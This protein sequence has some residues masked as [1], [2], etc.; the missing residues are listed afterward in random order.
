MSS[1]PQTPS[2]RLPLR[3]LPLIA[4]GAVL[5]GLVAVQAPA[6]AL[7]L[8]LAALVACVTFLAPNIAIYAV[9]FI[10][11][12]NLAGVGVAFHGVPKPIAAAFPLLLAIPLTWELL[13]RRQPLIVS[14]VLLILLLYLFVQAVSMAFSSDAVR[15]SDAVLTLAVEGV[16]LYLLITNTVRSTPVL[17]N[18]TWALLLAGLL[19]S[20]VPLYQQVTRTFDNTYGGLAQAEGVGFRT[21]EV[22]EE[23]GGEVRQARLAGP[24]GEKNRYAQIMLMLVPLGLMRAFGERTRALR[25][26]ALA[27]TASIALGFVLAFS[28][29]GAFGLLCMIAVMAI[30][31]IID[32]RRLLLVGAGVG[33]LLAAM[34]QYWNRLAT[35]ASTTSLFSDEAA[36]GETADGATKRRVTEMLAAVRVFVDHPVIG[37]GPGMFKSYSQ[38]YGNRDALR[39]IESGRRAH[40]LFLEIA[41]ETGAL[42]LALFLALIFVTLAGLA[43]VRRTC[44]ESDPDLANL[45]TAYLLALVCYLSTGIF[46][47]LAYMR[48]FFLVLALGGAACQLA[49]RT[50]EPE[51]G[52]PELAPAG[53]TA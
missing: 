44:Q 31:R 22:T 4:A 36:A 12:S 45:A 20:I 48:Y 30:M 11:Y 17:R 50:R 38:E 8:S 43:Y 6:V 10:L 34:P 3:W 16:A 35:V 24:I 51:R 27:C 47:H 26:A 32:M 33:L 23:G 25:L 52:T 7:V 21:G 19:M 49:Y 2:A 53:G 13:F 18:A 40:S 5:A 15:S 41:A 29:G 42:G 39:R 46:L 37:V 9:L 28:R 14:P 1:Y